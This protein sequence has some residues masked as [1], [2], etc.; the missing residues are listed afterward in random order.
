MGPL[1]YIMSTGSF[2]GCKERP[3]RDADLSL[4]SSTVV[5]KGYSYTVLFRG[6]VS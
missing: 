2:S 4:P 1:S 3:G 6:D 5:M